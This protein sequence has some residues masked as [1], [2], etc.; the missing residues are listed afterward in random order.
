MSDPN[1]GKNTQSFTHFRPSQK[2]YRTRGPLTYDFPHPGGRQNTT[3]THTPNL[4]ERS[5]RRLDNKQLALAHDR[6]RLRLEG[7]AV[8]PLPQPKDYL[9]PW[10]RELLESRVPYHHRPDPIPRA[11]LFYHSTL[12]DAQVELYDD[13]STFILFDQLPKEIRIKIWKAALQIQQRRN[14]VVERLGTMWAFDIKQPFYSPEMLDMLGNPINRFFS[15]SKTPAVLQANSESREISLHT[16]IQLFPNRSLCANPVYF[17]PDFDCIT[18]RYMDCLDGGWFLRSISK[19]Q[20]KIFNKIKSLAL[21]RRGSRFPAQVHNR[22]LSWKTAPLGFMLKWFRSLDSLTLFTESFQQ[23]N[24]HFTEGCFGRLLRLR[25]DAERDAADKLCFDNILL[26]MREMKL[27]DP[28]FKI[29]KLNRQE[30]R[31]IPKSQHQNP[32]NYEDGGCAKVDRDDVIKCM[33]V[34]EDNLRH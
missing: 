17:N 32:Y 33:V 25:R 6:P 4:T 15:K 8:T 27:E 20:A 30:L 1:E 10:Q 26:W 5:Y 2:L 28:T 3:W 12:P 29:P 34:E 22:G 18:I 23:E 7:D 9:L 16:Y 13:F 11:N 31:H 21:S 19:E 14:V 24:A